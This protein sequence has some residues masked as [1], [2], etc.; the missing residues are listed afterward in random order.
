[1][2]GQE[3]LAFKGGGDELASVRGQLGDIA[4]GARAGAAGRAEGFAH[5]IGDVS[6]AVA[7]RRGG[8]LDEHGLQVTDFC[9]PRSNIFYAVFQYLLAT[10]FEEKPAIARFGL[11]SSG[12]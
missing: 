3:R 7:A 8:G 11:F 12:S 2:G 6:F 4:D 5:E 9:Q 10:L 1:L